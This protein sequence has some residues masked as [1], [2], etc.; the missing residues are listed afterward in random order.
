MVEYIWAAGSYNLAGSITIY[1]NSCVSHCPSLFKLDSNKDNWQHALP[2]LEQGPFVPGHLPIWLY[3]LYWKLEGSLSAHSWIELLLRVRA[4]AGQF[5][6][7]LR[8]YHECIALKS[9]PIAGAIVLLLFK[10]ASPH[11]M[12]STCCSWCC[13]PVLFR[14]VS[15]RS[16]KRNF[17]SLVCWMKYFSV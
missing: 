3:W 5:L 9:I 6:W 14:L 10:D 1:L 12:L 13:D 15:S 8:A 16:L 7:E 11:F 17:E 2:G 4:R